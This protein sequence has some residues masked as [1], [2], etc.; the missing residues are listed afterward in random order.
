MHTVQK[1]FKRALNSPLTRSGPPTYLTQHVLT[2][3]QDEFLL[4]VE[5]AG[6]LLYDIKRSDSVMGVV[7]TFST[8]F[9]SITSA[10]VTGSLAGLFTKLA[11]ELSDDLPF[12]QSSSWIDVCDDFYKNI[13]RVKDCALG[14]KLIKVLNHVIA[15]TFYFKMGISVDDKIFSQLEKNYIQPTVWNVLTFADAIV[16]LLLFLAKAGRQAILTGSAD[17]FFVDS[18][19]VSNWLLKANHLRKDA[20]FLGN[21]AAIGLDT[22]TYLTD[23]ADAIE[24][25]K[26]LCKSFWESQKILVNN[27]IVELE[28]VQKRYQS[29]M[30]AASFRFCPIGLFIWG[31]S[32]VGKSF[33]VKGLF[34]HYASVRD[35]KKEK[36]VLYSR[37]P[38]DKYY[39][40]FKSSMLGI[41]YDDVAKHKASKVMGIDQ[42]LADI[43]GAVNNI[44]LITNQAEAFDKGKIPMPRLLQ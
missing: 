18:E 29:A 28:M 31:D 30:A 36:A 21:P 4:Y 25:G 12:W 11:E 33:I 39:S 44:P 17:A 42:S 9:R 37:N 19:T 1:S 24:D 22:I 23:V 43:I 5:S 27:V 7:I 16:G 14:K 8:F 26:R 35:I 20:E 15:H 32:G 6:T 3:S 10:S 34:Y 2:P 13:H 40:G 38:D 41:L